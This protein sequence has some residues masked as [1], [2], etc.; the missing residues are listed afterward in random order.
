MPVPRSMP[1]PRPFESWSHLTAYQRGAILEKA[2]L[3]IES[4][5]DEFARITTEE[6]GK[7]I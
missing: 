6:A 2:A 4:H 5:L 3:F 1:Q 7:P